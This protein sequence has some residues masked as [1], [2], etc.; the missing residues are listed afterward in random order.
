MTEIGNAS[1]LTWDWREQPNLAE[2]AE[3]LL[4]LTNGR[5]HLKS[6]DTG[7]D[8][9]AVVIS[10]VELDQA[11]VNAAYDVWYRRDDPP[12]VFEVSA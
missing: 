11:A 8:Q 6:V 10:T 4:E 3:L 5:L 7:S 1:I 12:T 9:Y 2:L